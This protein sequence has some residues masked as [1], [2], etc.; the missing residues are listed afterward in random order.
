MANADC[1]ICFPAC[2]D[3]AGIAEVTTEAKVISNSVKSL[4]LSCWY[5]GWLPVAGWRNSGAQRD[6]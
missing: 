1:F 6:Y 4:S 2:F 3:Q 5:R